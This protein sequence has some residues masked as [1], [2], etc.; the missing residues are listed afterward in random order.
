[1][2]TRGFV[3]GDRILG[4]AA[5]SHADWI[6]SYGQLGSYRFVGASAVGKLHRS[7]A[8]PR[9]DAFALRAAGSWLAVAV[10]D[11]VGE[12]PRSRYGS[13]YAVEALCEYMLRERLGLSA[14]SSQAAALSSMVNQNEQSGSEKTNVVSRST[15]THRGKKRRWLFSRSAPS[16]PRQST[17]VFD[18]PELP[19]VADNPAFSCGTLTWYELLPS[20]SSSSE[21]SP[22]N[23]VGGLGGLSTNATE[24]F[25]DLDNRECLIRAFR[26]TRQGLEQFAQANH[27]QLRELA[28]TLLGV[29]LNT[30]T[31][32]M[33]AGQIGD[34]LIL[35]L[36]PGLGAKP[37]VE[38]ALPGEAGETY[39]LTQSNWEQYL[40]VRSYKAQET[41]GIT[42]VYLM[43]DGVSEDCTHP[44]PAD[45]LQKWAHSIDQ[46]LRKEEPLPQ[47]AIRLLRWLAHYDA[48]GSFDDR[49][50]LMLMR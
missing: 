43:T 21:S 16:Q 9:D 38:A 7:K 32:E 45:I 42:T 6:A 25:A 30:E 37:L 39:T 47:T 29:L 3:I 22:R 26:S 15:V 14:S 23:D 34:G 19:A 40:T 31:G 35:A 18:F 28:S 46:Q 48:P 50:L 10:S 20:I 27:F 44:P 33:V 2:L 11:G 4:Q 36:H 5:D 17:P 24:A 12:C 8:R 49:T 1:M 13:T 41:A